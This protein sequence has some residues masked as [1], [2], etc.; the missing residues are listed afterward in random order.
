VF[1]LFIC[2]K[3]NVFTGKPYEHSINWRQLQQA[4]PWSIMLLL[5]GGLVMADGFKVIIF[6]LKNSKI[7]ISFIYKRVLVYQIGS[8]RSSIR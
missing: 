4:F 3:E 8:V 1:L 2:P 7:Q 6:L 5:G